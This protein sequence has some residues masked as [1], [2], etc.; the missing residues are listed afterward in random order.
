MKRIKMTIT[1]SSRIYPT[2]AV[3]SSKKRRKRREEADHRARAAEQRVRV[4]QSNRGN[5]N[6][7]L[8]LPKALEAFLEVSSATF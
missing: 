3:R 8:Q 5:K 2:T 4:S 7:A 1:V 6:L